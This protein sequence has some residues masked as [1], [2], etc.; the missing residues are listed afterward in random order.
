MNA[1]KPF[2]RQ[3]SLHAGLVLAATLGLAL[4]LPD[5]T[6]A[7]ACQPACHHVA[8]PA[9]VMGQATV[10]LSWP[11]FLRSRTRMFQA[12]VV[13][14]GLGIFILTRGRWK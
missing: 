7:T 8:T 2:R 9:P 14:M 6:Q 1:S 5:S 11:A 4:V 10:G 12:A 13:I 3:A